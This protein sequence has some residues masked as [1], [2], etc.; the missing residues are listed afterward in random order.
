M[1]KKVYE[2]DSQD[3]TGNKFS[4]Q[5]S[6]GRL[7]VMVGLWKKMVNTT[8]IGDWFRSQVYVGQTLVGKESKA[9]NRCQL[10]SRTF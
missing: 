5:L 6:S 1:N 8:G 7:D 4:P 10:K 3:G 2:L 9:Q